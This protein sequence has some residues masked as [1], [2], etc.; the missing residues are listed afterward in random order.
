MA[1]IEIPT[2]RLSIFYSLHGTKCNKDTW[3]KNLQMKKIYMQVTIKNPQIL[4]D[5][6]NTHPEVITQTP[7]LYSPGW[8][9]LKLC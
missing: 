6:S 1:N 3:K 8:N 5:L 4:D 9:G 7:G 2:A